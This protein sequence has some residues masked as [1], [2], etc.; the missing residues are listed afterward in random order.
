MPATATACLKRAVP[1]PEP[2][3][4]AAAP[5]LWASLKESIRGTEQDFTEG[6]ISRAIILL[7][8]P[9]VLE[10]VMESVFAITDVF[11]VSRL[12]A[13]AI[14]TVGL[15][16]SL[17]T[18]V[19]AISIGLSIG[20]MAVVARRIGQKD[21]EQAAR[22]AVQAIVLGLVAS[23]PLSITGILAARPLLTMMGASPWVLAH[24]VPYAQVEL[25][26]SAV[27]LLLFLINAI[28]RGTGDAAISMRVLWLSNSINILLAPCFI[29]GLGPFPHLGVVGASVA[30][31]IGRSTGV[32]Y[33]LW[34]LTRGDG[35]VTVRRRHLKVE[36]GTLWAM[37]RLSGSAIVQQVVAMSSWLFLVRIVSLFGSVAVAGYTIAIRIILF[38]LLPSMGLGNAAA[39]LVG[40]GL[41]AG[42]P[43]RGERAVAVAG[44][45]SVGFLGAVSVLFIAFAGPLISIFTHDPLVA[46]HGVR[47]LRIVSAGFVFYGYGMV[48]TQAF[49]GAADTLTPTVLNFVCF[50]LLELPLA[51]FLCVPWGLGPTGAFVS[52][53]LSFSVL[54]VASWALFRR[55]RWKLRTL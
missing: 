26:A 7:A 3:A 17:I 24:G 18:V 34:R 10:M 15:T 5:S 9:M 54:A 37:L 38:A 13:D 14:A 30:T 50:W 6:T 29:F 53:A 8:V 16:E 36:V 21:P 22:G 31:T 44:L 11:F 51:Y 19:Y 42:K 28:F 55:G 20:A 2:S 45:Y 27:L 52:I 43:E 39:T 49:N 23:V 41:G 47:C 40:Q 48:V 32:A 46:T 4:S 12:G 1:A 25:G 33:Q 35:R